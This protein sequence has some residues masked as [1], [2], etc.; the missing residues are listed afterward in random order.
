MRLR[1]ETVLTL[2][3]VVALLLGCKAFEKIAGDKTANANVNKSTETTK[4]NTA[5]VEP[6]EEGTIPSGTGVEKEKPAAGKANVQGKAL[7][8][9]KPAVGV[10]VKLCKTFNRFFGGCSG[11]T[12][13][14]KTDESG[15]Y[16]IKNVPPGIYEGL[17]VKVFNTPYYVFATSGVIAAAKYKIGADQTYFAP[18]TNLFKND[19]KLVNPKSGSKVGAE[20]LEVKWEAYPDAAYYKLSFF[21]DATTGAEA[22]YDFIGKRVE[23][24]SII[25]DKPLKPGTYNPKIEAY[26]ANDQKLAQSAEDLKF[27]VK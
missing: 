23:D 11:D 18:D 9:D 15:E 12:F 16:L 26:N 2:V 27:T 13:T 7:Y 21:A 10:E 5:A 17:T 25:V 4:A 24:V 1:S 20:G 3:I 8:D 14:A 19:L 6:D 22:P